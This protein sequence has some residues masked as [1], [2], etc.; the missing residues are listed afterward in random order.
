[1]RAAGGGGNRPPP[2]PTLPGMDAARPGDPV[3][4]VT[5]VHR[6]LAEH[7]GATGSSIDVLRAAVPHRTFVWHVVV[8]GAGPPGPPVPGADTCLW[9]G[10]SLGVSAARNAALAGVGGGW[11]FRVDGDDL[12]DSDGWAGLLAD[13]GFGSA[14]W[15]ATNLLTVDGEPTPHWFDRPRTWA[16]GEVAEAWTTPM[17]F[18]PNNIVADAS[19]VLAVGGWPAIGVNED[20]AFCFAINDLAAGAALP[21]VTLRYRKWAHQTVAGDTYVRDKAAAFAF[22]AA[23]ATARRARYGGRAVRAPAV[24]PGSLYLPDGTAPR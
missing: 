8:D 5:A 4:L 17:V 7:L 12:V 3:H 19:L 21:H 9:A 22:I 16:A 1:M 23:S 20:I 2:V 18:H 14:P 13:P 10:R 11:V 15:C 6:D 24:L